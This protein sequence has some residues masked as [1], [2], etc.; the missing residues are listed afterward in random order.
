MSSD[1]SETIKEISKD[2]CADKFD[3]NKCYE[4]IDAIISISTYNG[5]SAGVCGKSSGRNYTFSSKCD[6]IN[7]DIKKLLQ[8]TK[9][10][11]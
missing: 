7:S 2:L 3:K 6:D 8:D 4:A 10:K 1:A 9:N 5:Y 11:K